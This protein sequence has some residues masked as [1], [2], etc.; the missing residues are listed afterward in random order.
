[1]S[2]EAEILK[3][4]GGVFLG[5]NEWGVVPIVIF[6]SFGFV[7]FVI[8]VIYFFSKFIGKN[9]DKL[10]EIIDRNTR[11]N[12]QLNQSIRVNNEINEKRLNDLDGGIKKSL[13]LHGRTH[14]ELREIKW[15]FGSK[16]K[17]S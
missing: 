9:Q 15:L 1:M 14:D 5:M 3:E 12:E 16:N 13:E 2:K 8:G 6:F 17:E 4:T 10:G 11:S 7:L